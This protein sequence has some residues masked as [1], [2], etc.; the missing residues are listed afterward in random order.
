MLIQIITHTVYTI[1]CLEE[2]FENAIEII[3]RYD[4]K[5]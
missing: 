1:S 5:F 4:N 3:R 2:E